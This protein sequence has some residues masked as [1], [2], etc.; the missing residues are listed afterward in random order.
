MT[1]KTKGAAIVGFI[2]AAITLAAAFGYD[3]TAFVPVTALESAGPVIDNVL[4]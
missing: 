4:K 1:K 3:I 2:F